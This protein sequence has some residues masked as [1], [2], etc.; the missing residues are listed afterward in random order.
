MAGVW[1]RLLRA[2]VVLAA[3]GA[4][5]TGALAHPHVFVDTGVELRFD[6]EG[7]LEA[8]RIVWVYDDFV[9]LMIVAERGLDPD[10][11]GVL[12]EAETAALTG[13][14]MQWD[15]GF[16]GDTYLLADG[17]DLAL[18]PHRRGGG[19]MT[20]L[21]RLA[22]ATVA[23]MF[24]CLVVLY[25]VAPIFVGAS[26]SVT[27]GEFLA[28]PPQGFSNRWYANIA[29]DR[30]WRAAFFNSLIIGA[31]AASIA[32]ILG[33]LSAYG[34]A[35]TQNPILRRVLIVLFILPLAVPHMSLAMA[36]YTNPH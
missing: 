20:P 21:G 14:D 5:G 32:T 29:S 12:T 23:G 34:I 10:G 2:G 7:R 27:G 19:S 4:S 1:R 24:L 13:F 35:L 16:A 11:D 3:L 26:V 8:L 15:E 25:M 31:L 36:F 9:S 18:G 22:T 30:L 17:R 28:F 6:A 33:T